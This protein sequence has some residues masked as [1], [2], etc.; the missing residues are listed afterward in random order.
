M[1][2]AKLK[3]AMEEGPLALANHMNLY[4]REAFTEFG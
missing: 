2:L 3:N 4:T 1:F